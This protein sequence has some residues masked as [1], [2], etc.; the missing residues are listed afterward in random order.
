M[1]GL[2]YLKDV[3]TLLLDDETGFESFGRVVDRVGNVLRDL[4]ESCRWLA[5]GYCKGLNL[6]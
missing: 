6:C 4:A 5:S 2:V 3:T 1:K